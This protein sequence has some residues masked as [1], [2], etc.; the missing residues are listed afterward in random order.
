MHVMWILTE[1]KVKNC[2]GRLV[3]LQEI[4]TIYYISYYNAIIIVMGRLDAP[5]FISGEGYIQ[6]KEEE[7]SVL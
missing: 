2:S 4:T 6:E 7:G 3:N 1:S 5:L